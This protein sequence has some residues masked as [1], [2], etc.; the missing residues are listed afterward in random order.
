MGRAACVS[1][2]TLKR[3]GAHIK[4]AMDVSINKEADALK[5]RVTVVVIGSE[6][7]TIGYVVAVT[8]STS[9]VVI[10]QKTSGCAVGFR[11]RT[12]VFANVI[13]DGGILMVVATLAA[14]EHV[15]NGKINVP[16]RHLC[17]QARKGYSGGIHCQS[18]SSRRDS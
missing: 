15:M 5:V 3:L 14:K 4:T 6:N 7:Y 16:L 11:V 9:D 8:A 13:G 2:L 18:S 12:A 10:W 17:N 1:A